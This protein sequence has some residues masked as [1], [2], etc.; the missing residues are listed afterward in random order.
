MAR[1]SRIGS[2]GQ[3]TVPL[4]V[5]KRLGLREGDLVEFVTEGMVTFIRP[6]RG[7]GNP[8]DEYAGALHT[9][10]GGRDEIHAWVKDLRDDERAG[11]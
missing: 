9:F 3:I 1:T 6:V 7:A 4:D 8:F 10:P 5:R 11:E 2:N